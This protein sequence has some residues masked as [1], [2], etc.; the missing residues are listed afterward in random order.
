MLFV[1]C[2]DWRPGDTNL[3]TFSQ[4]EKLIYVDLCQLESFLSAGPWLGSSRVKIVE[5]NPPPRHAEEKRN[6]VAGS[7]AGLSDCRCSEPA[8]NEI[9]EGTMIRW[10]GEPTPSHQP[11]GHWR[12]SPLIQNMLCYKRC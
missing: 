2:G 7:S 11:A 8:D 3:S 6:K 1:I 4:Q 10:G 5:T 9:G 12:L